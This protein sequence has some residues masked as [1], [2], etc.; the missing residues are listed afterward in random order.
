MLCRFSALFCMGVA[1]VLA[2]DCV[3]SNALEAGEPDAQPTQPA[4]LSPAV[5]LKGYHSKVVSLDFSPDGKRL[6]GVGLKGPV[7]SW[8]LVTRKEL[9][10]FRGQAN[11]DKYF[12]CLAL[13]PTGKSLA[14]ASVQNAPRGPSKYVVRLLDAS[15][16]D[17]RAR[18][19]TRAVAIHFSNDGKKFA[20]IGQVPGQTRT[21]MW[22]A[23][24]GRPLA[25]LM[26]RHGYAYAAA[27][28]RDYKALAAVIWQVDGSHV[29]LWDAVAGKRIAILTGYARH[30]YS[31]AFS[32]DGKTLALGTLKLSGKSPVYEPSGVLFFDVTTG[33][34]RAILPGQPT[35]VDAITFSRDGKLLASASSDG[36]IYL[37]DVATKRKTAT[38][39]GPRG[40]RITCLAF[41]P[42]GRK[43]AAGAGQFKHRGGW[44]GSGQVMVWEVPEAGSNKR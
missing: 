31:P 22:D 9:R 27:F 19:P 37:W 44:L 15:T 10:V 30:K 21:R 26:P 16:F 12:L 39:R 42:D 2:A 33:K 14:V 4:A 36:T 23:A 18:I 29:E 5:A 1:G 32:P 20:T 7:R 28:S 3:H 38:L 11:R 13:D 8:S 34:R 41:S 6:V 25:V 24:T 35:D 43:L 40:W 17:V